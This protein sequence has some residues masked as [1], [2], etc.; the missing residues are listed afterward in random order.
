MSQNQKV[1]H[2]RAIESLPSAAAEV[3]DVPC[4]I[5]GQISNTWRAHAADKLAG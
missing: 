3:A 4:N 5:L 2:L 1:N